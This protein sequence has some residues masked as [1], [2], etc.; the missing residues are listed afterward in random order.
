MSILYHFAARVKPARPFGLGLEPDDAGPYAEPSP[1][2]RLWLCREYDPRREAEADA[3]DF[4]EAHHR[5]MDERAAE[6]EYEDRTS[7][8]HGLLAR[9]IAEALVDSSLI[10]HQP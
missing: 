4:E 5:H 9:H 3:R 2:D 1:A 7:G 10:G 8:L 6:A